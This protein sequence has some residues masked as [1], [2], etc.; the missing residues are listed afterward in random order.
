M[1]KFGFQLYETE[2]LIKQAIPNLFPF[3]IRQVLPGHIL[4]FQVHCS[5]LYCQV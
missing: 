2:F 5:K 3:G 1:Q 4:L